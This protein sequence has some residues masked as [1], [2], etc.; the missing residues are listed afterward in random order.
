MLIIKF[1]R[2]DIIEHKITHNYFYVRDIP[3]TT[4]YVPFYHLMPLTYSN[5][6]YDMLPWI[7]DKQIV[8]ADW[9]LLTPIF[10]EE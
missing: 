9:I 5:V 6:S 10:R 4:P 1:E 8:E 2:G 7:Y 3:K